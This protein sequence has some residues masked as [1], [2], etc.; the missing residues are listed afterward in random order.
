MELTVRGEVFKIT[1]VNNYVHEKYLELMDMVFDIQ[2]VGDD[3]EKALKDT[4]APE[5]TKDK[6][7]ALSK[8]AREIRKEMV[9]IRREIWERACSRTDMNTQRNGG[10]EKR[11]MKI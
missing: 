2:D 10:R 3:I 11:P 1:L 8:R 9:M 5:N 7:K 6:I 4:S